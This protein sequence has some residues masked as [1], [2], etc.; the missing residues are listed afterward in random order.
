MAVT[1]YLKFP[2]GELLNELGEDKV[3]NILSEFSCPQNADIE[4]F[5]K[6]K[7]IEFEYHGWS[8]TQLIYASYKD[9]PVLVGYYSLANKTLLIDNQQISRSLRKRLNQFAT[10]DPTIKKS[11][12]S[13]PLIGQLGKNFYCKYN[14][15]ITGD[16]LLGIAL[17]DVKMS[18]TILGGK[19]VYL[20]CEDKPNLIDFYS[21]N[22]FV[23]FDKRLLDKDETDISGEYLVQMLKYIK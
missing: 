21:R 14:K 3:R 22:G 16:E 17:E 18:Q 6:K 11:F 7:S 19:F 1:G 10:Y 8:A 20:E 2:L 13:A 4:N 9:V 5:I 12:I 23:E 15:L